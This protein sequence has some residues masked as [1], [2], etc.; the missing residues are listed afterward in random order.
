MNEKKDD[1][2]LLERPMILTLLITGGVIMIVM[3]LKNS[4]ILSGLRVFIHSLQAFFFGILFAYLLNPV[5]SFFDKKYTKYLSTSEKPRTKLCKSL[6][7]ATAVLIFIGIV[8][9]LILTIVPQLLET[10]RT[11]IE[12]SAYMIRDLV[13]WMKGLSD[14]EFWQGKV[15]P[16]IQNLLSDASG[17]LSRLAGEGADIV[18]AIS[19]GIISILK[20]ILNCV[21]GL[22]IAVYILISKEKL[23]AQIR[24]VTYAILPTRHGGPALEIMNEANRILE[25]YL[26]GKIIDSL[27]IGLIALIGMFVLRLPYVLLISA[28]ICITNMIP[29]FGPYLGAVF[30]A[31][32]I[33]MV[34]PIQ[35]IYF[36]IFVLILQQVDGN[37]IGPKILGDSTG[38]DP[39]WIVV[40]VMVFGGCFGFV[41]MILGV[42]VF[43]WIYY[44]VKRLCEYSLT[45]K[46]LP[47][48]TDSYLR[49]KEDAELEKYFPK[50]AEP[51]KKEE[52]IMEI[53]SRRDC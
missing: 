46:G 3:L 17:W 4:G 21:V 7:L 35:T 51:P 49:G 33:L 15:I 2:G 27:I 10:S 19:S 37:I 50:A 42:P 40:A 6:S 9:L 25:G 30:G 12:N 43:A 26:V 23:F 36:V 44:I 28:V 14:G 22:I 5:A 1:K 20:I 18:S 47:I 39:M 52:E 45:R 13:R 11:L 31:I 24:K 38:L 34:N 41:G 32:L 8:L 48:H 29:F 53:V 16:S